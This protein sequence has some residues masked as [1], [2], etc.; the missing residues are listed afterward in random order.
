MDYAGLLLR[1]FHILPAIALA[2]G[3]IFMRW[4]L[5]AASA[6]LDEASRTSLQ[7]ALRGRWAKVFTVWCSGK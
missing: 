3:V 5:A 7:N 4:P 2:G 1:W 6:E